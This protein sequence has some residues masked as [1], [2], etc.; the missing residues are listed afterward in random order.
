MVLPPVQRIEPASKTM[1]RIQALPDTA[2][3][4]KDRESVF[5]FNLREIPPKSEKPNVL[6]LAM[7]TRLKVFYRPK[8]IIV[9]EMADV[10]RA[11]KR[12]S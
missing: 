3:L 12:W 6:M 2:Q 4:P 9:D 7:Q 10:V 1:V 8:G 11:L 5:Y